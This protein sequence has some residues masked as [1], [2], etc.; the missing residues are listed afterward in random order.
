MVVLWRQHVLYITTRYLEVTQVHCR[1]ASSTS[2]AAEWIAPTIPSVRML[3][4]QTKPN[5]IK[6]TLCSGYLTAK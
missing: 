4:K 5:Q 1:E 3:Q 6:P 2:D